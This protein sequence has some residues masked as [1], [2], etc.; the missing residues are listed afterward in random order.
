M[1]KADK[2]KWLS[3]TISWAAR[4]YYECIHLVQ[5]IGFGSRTV[6]SG[7]QY[8]GDYFVENGLHMHIYVP[9]INDCANNVSRKPERDHGERREESK[10]IISI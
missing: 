3:A 5:Q 10:A 1:I 4:T 2:L 7:D 8:V 9:R 6:I